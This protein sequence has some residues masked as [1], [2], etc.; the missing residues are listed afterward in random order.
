M[1]TLKEVKELKDKIQKAQKE[2][3]NA[4]KEYKKALNELTDDLSIFISKRVGIATYIVFA[5]DENDVDDLLALHFEIT[6]D[7]DYENLEYYAHTKIGFA[8]SGQGRG[9]I[10]GETRGE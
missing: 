8:I 1:T 10:C 3:E 9:V 2:L 6:R 5:L 7:D 4:E